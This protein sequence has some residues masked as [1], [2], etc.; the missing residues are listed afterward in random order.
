MNDEWGSVCK[1]NRVV[2]RVLWVTA[3]VVFI[4]ITGAISFGDDRQAVVKIGDC[5][6]VCVDPAG[7]VLTAKHCEHG[8]VE[9]VVFLDR[10]VTAHRV[11]VTDEVEG[12][13]VFDCEG[14]GFPFL[15]LADR[16]PEIGEVVSSSGYPA[17]GGQRVFRRETGTLLR[18]GKFTFQGQPFFGNITD[19]ALLPGWSGGPLLNA[20]GDVCGLLSASNSETSV[21][22][23]FAAIRTAYEAVTQT[24]QP[25]LYVFT[26]RNCS[27]CV[28]FKADYDSDR[29][30]RGQLQTAFRVEFVDADLRPDLAK[31]YNVVE[32]PT[33]VVPGRVRV[34]GYPGKQPL[35]DRLLTQTGEWVSAAPVDWSQV[36]I[37]LLAAEQEV[38][39]IR[40]TLRGQLLES[41][42]GPLQRRVAEATE[43]KAGLT[44]VAERNNPELYAM[45]SQAARVEVPRFH[46]L[47]L[48]RQQDLGLKGLILGVIEKIVG[49]H[50][51]TVPVDLIFE[52]VHPEDYA[53][54]A[55]ALNGIGYEEG[56]LLP[57]G[58]PND[59]GKF[60]VQETALGG[61]LAILTERLKLVRKFTGWW[62]RRKQK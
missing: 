56:T 13:V 58:E 21:F 40:G 26:T 55:S 7:L 14:D 44:I 8:L 33:F 16:V 11:Y 43:G 45:I 25:T 22:I 29:A 52:R 51:G 34:Q 18:G 4:V 57:G 5:S 36:S 37:I 19:M 39:R 30:F 17:M 32:V 59:D 35:A 23:T 6:G 10:R 15:P 31:Q 42:I 49:E 27:S 28:R 1:R 62:Q 61:I 20:R 12:P 54:V 24:G 41:A 48:V 9:T 53:R 38:G 46:V 3:L 50:L 2:N 47:V 60:P